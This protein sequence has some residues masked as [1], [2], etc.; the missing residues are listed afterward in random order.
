MLVQPLLFISS[1]PAV[2]QGLFLFNDTIVI[3]IPKKMFLRILTIL[4]RSSYFQLKTLIDIFVVDYPF[5]KR[6]FEINYVFWSL[7]F[8]RRFIIRFSV[9]VAES[10]PT[11][12][13]LFSSANWLEREIW[14]LFGVVFSGHSDLRRI[15][16]DYGFRGHPLRKDFPLTG[17]LEVR[18]DEELKTVVSETIEITQE[19]RLF[20]FQSP[21]EPPKR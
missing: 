10:A 21:W 7:R 5:R 19:F 11:I 9:G 16:T 2:F 17:F 1:L 4:V 8:N 3:T 14:D 12:S 6:R 18:F 15:L 20:E 13:H